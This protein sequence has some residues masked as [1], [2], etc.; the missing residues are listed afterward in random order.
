MDNLNKQIYNS[1]LHKDENIISHK[2]EI[3]E[4]DFKSKIGL[5]KHFSVSHGEQK[6]RKCNV[7]Q[8]K[9]LIQSYLS[10]HITLNQKFFLTNITFS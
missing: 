9:F 10:S 7:C 5:R 6:P 1:S 4:K 8:K 3:C 2:C